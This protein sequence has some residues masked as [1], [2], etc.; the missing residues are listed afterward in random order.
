MVRIR[1]VLT[2][3]GDMWLKYFSEAIK[4]DTEFQVKD[5]HYFTRIFNFYLV[6][7]YSP[8]SATQFKMTSNNEE[9][10]ILTLIPLDA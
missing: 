1:I 6:N 2:R 9:V 5:D 4:K 10:R 8:A 7:Y 3:I